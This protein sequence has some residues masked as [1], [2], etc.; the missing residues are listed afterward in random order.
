MTCTYCNIDEMDSE[1]TPEEC[2]GNQ[3]GVKLGVADP[4]SVGV[5]ISDILYAVSHRGV[6]VQPIY[7]AIA[8]HFPDV[9]QYDCR[10]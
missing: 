7:D 6:A 10:A 2:Y 8:R 9:V 4:H 3:I 1:H 5:L